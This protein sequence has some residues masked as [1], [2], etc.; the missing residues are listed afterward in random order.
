MLR[1]ASTLPAPV[2][3]GGDAGDDD[4]DDDDGSDTEVEGGGEGDDDSEPETEMEQSP[5]KG[6]GKA[7]TLSPLD[8]LKG[9][10]KSKTSTSGKGVPTPSSLKI[11]TVTEE[12]EGPKE[13]SLLERRAKLSPPLLRDAPPPIAVAPVAPPPTLPANSIARQPQPITNGEPQWSIGSDAGPTGGWTNFASTTPSLTPLKPNPKTPKAGTSGL[14][15]TSDEGGYFG[16][17]TV[18]P[19]PVAVETNTVA[20]LAPPLDAGLGAPI[21]SST[22]QLS[23]HNP[24]I[25]IASPSSGNSSNTG[26]GHDGSEEGSENTNE[27]S[28]T[29][30]PAMSSYPQSPAMSS[31]PQSPAVFDNTRPTPVKRPSL[32]HQA[33]RSLE[34]LTRAAS[35][36]DTPEDDLALE[37]TL[38]HGS[39]TMSR[40]TTIT[41]GQSTRSKELPS[42]IE[43]PKRQSFLREATGPSTP[44]WLRAPPTPATPGAAG[45]VFWGAS[46]KKGEGSGG[47]P[48]RRR[49]AG[50]VELPPPGYEPPHP[51][52]VIPRP[53]D[54]EGREVLPGY[55][56]AV[57][58]FSQKDGN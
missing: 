34:N 52:V 24:N 41:S 31:Y 28:R 57:S 9:K 49:S 50:D 29:Q 39:D 27:T 17:V 2:D 48:K 7:K 47:K 44:G 13:L 55:W 58:Q 6:K 38:V 54:D 8:R 32:Y 40:L 46:G 4:D 30:S 51:G 10:G 37:P 36:D 42:R 33:T 11:S 3:D 45:Q 12:E 35:P 43:I 25:P 19:E 26:E 5:V 53:R 18:A 15:K 21:S 23:P 1:Q 14:R 20:P 56:C 16:N 22:A